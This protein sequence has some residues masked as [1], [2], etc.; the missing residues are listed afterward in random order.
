[1]NDEDKKIILILIIGTNPLPNFIVA[2][3][4]IY[5]IRKLILIYSEENNVQAGTGDYTNSIQEVLPLNNVE[6]ELISLEDI[7]SANRIR[8]DLQKKLNINPYDLIHLNYT[9]GTKSMVVHI[10]NFIK[11]KNPRA[12]FSYL[13]ARKYKIVY[14]NGD[15]YPKNG[16]LRDIII[17][18]MDDLL[19][20]HL[21]KR[22]EKTKKSPNS[23]VLDKLD[24]LIKKDKI[25]QFIRWIE[26]IDPLYKR[27]EKLLER[28]TRF[29]ENSNH[30]CVE[31]A[32]NNFEN[33][34]DLV[35]DI[36]NSFP[37]K[38]RLNKQNDKNLW[39]PEDIISN[40]EFKER[41][42]ETF[43]FLDGKWLEYYI[44]NKI[45]SI[46]TSSNEKISIGQSI[47]A[48]NKKSK[49]FEL[50]LYIIKGYQLL[51]ISVTTIINN[52]G[53]CKHKGFEIIHRI[54]QIG[55]DEGIS[56]LIT[57][58]SK[59][60]IRSLNDDLEYATGSAHGLVFA[61]GIEDWKDI[62]KKIEEVLKL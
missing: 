21:Y 53:L 60:D 24:A 12:F 49:K 34:S 28:K 40:K 33:M 8:E 44:Y 52:V 10:Y 62:S 45:L 14:D 41:I 61:F 26:S 7:S 51:G 2:K 54:K 47:E 1:M 37:E 15:Y 3:F 9:G 59:N 22:N 42:K 32:I 48:Y 6:L 43:E 20:L 57:G 17:L 11:K 18:T 5:Q 25:S 39:I 27:E 4:Y 58:L 16:D 35:L 13:D 50:D 23:T 36:L 46:K 38:K 19:K 30:P 56:I 29:I 31:E 55:G